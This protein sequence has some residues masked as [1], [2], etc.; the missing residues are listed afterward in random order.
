MARAE[1][2]DGKTV[3][4]AIRQ[5]IRDQVDDYW[6][7]HRQRPGLAVVLVG[8]DP[9]SHVYVRNKRR[10]CED[11]HIAS[12]EHRLPATAR[13][14][15]VIAVVRALNEDDKVHGILVQ[16]PLPPQ[17]KADRVLGEIHPA[18]DVDGLTE[19][20]LGR[21]AA[22]RPGLR[23]CTP[24]GVLELLDR[25]HIP[26]AGS[27]ACVIGRSQLV[28]LPMALMLLQRQATVTVIHSH[29]PNPALLAREADLVVAA[30][31]RPGLVTPDWIRRGA[32]VVDVGTTRTADGLV[33]DVVPEVWD[34][35]GYVTPVPGGVGPM[36]IAGLIR[37]TWQAFTSQH[38][39]GGVG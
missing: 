28:G 27:R 14:E 10:A 34:V 3:G 19:V 21:L 22:G 23:P 26:L 15:D 20:N 37:N 36:T 24:C 6:Q 8:D 30:A 1:R 17:V 9:A 4:L 5:E 11:A 16:L 31:G 38:Q 18:K 32:T 12:F 33:G 29:T 25:Y 39:G 2:L 13:T 7:R 35:A